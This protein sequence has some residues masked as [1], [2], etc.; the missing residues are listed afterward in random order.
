MLST[1][2]DLVPLEK[3]YSCD[4]TA[5]GVIVTCTHKG[6]TYVLLG[7]SSSKKAL[8]HFHGWND[9]RNINS[10]KTTPFITACI[11]TASRE[12]SEESLEVLSSRE[13]MKKVLMTENY[14]VKGEKE[15]KN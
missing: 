6:F 2:F 1:N 3:K 9:E 15:T 14:M 4:L 12:Y 13:H 10:G 5:C 7:V 8:C 11:E